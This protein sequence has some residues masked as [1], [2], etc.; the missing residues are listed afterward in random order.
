M[1][2]KFEI[3][4]MTCAACSSYIDKAVRKIDG[5]NDVSVNLLQNNMT[6]DYDHSLVTESDIA[7]AV[8]KGGYQTFKAGSSK[9]D[10]ANS[11]KQVDTLKKNFLNLILS[12]ALMI[13][14]WYLA[15]ARMLDFP[16][17]EFVKANT[18]IIV[19]GILQMVI[20]SLIL[21]INKKFF[22]SGFKALVNLAPNM[23]S[24]IAIGSGASFIYSFYSLL[25]MA[26]LVGNGNITLALEYSMNLYF[27]SAAMI[28]VFI[29]IG[30]LMESR[31]KNETK[32]SLNKLKKLEVA[33]ATVIR[34]NKKINIKSEDI[35]IGDIVELKAGSKIATDGVIITGSVSIDE[36][37][38]TGE[39]I[40]KDKDV[41]GKV[42][43]GS[44][45]TSGY[46]TYKVESL[47]IDS[48][49][50][51]I[52]ALVEDAA[53]SKAP[54]QR[55][56]DKISAVFVPF[57]ISV[58]I[59]VFII[60]FSIS[61]DFSLS[62]TFAIAVLVVSCPCA[63][64]LATPT[65]IMVA[66][67]K[68]A[69][70][71]ILF[72]EAKG[73]EHLGQV[74]TIVFDKTGTLTEG[75]AKV[76]KIIMLDDK[77]KTL[78]VIKSIEAKS[79]HPLSKAIV[80]YMDDKAIEEVEV[81]D[82]TAII[83]QGVMANYNGQAIRIGNL[84]MMELNG[85]DLEDHLQTFEEL[86]NQGATVLFVAFDKEIKAIISI[87]DQVKQD[88]LKT[89]RALKELNL[90]LVMLTGDNKLTANAIKKTLGI[91]QVIAEVLP[92]EKADVIKNLQNENHKVLMVGDG[93][94]D[95][96]ALTSSDISMAIANGTEIAVDSADIVLMNNNLMAIYDAF[97]L[98]K[99]TLTN[100]K[101]NLFL[102]LIYNVIGIPLAAGAFYKLFNLRLTPM[103]GAGTMAIS[104]T[105]VVMN[106]LRLKRFKSKQ[107]IKNENEEKLI[108]VEN[109]KENIKM[110]KVIKIEGMMCSHCENHVNEALNGLDGVTAKVVLSENLAN[111]SVSN[112]VK[113]E[114]LEQAVVN[115]GYKVVSIESR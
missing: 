9:K 102:A 2:E 48:T 61:K 107:T 26:Y 69:E 70:M 5:V 93:I 34:D 64:G 114:D 99:A 74:D 72:K 94:N 79:E 35:L 85:L 71:K 110:E 41:E 68:A 15:M 8:S 95:A 18:S 44:L 49:L 50:A 104:S 56:A 29:S 20:S 12:V 62:L 38:L 31:S 42:Y 66:T 36:A 101:Q 11:K 88:A 14:L 45:V 51:K 40:P 75:K 28:L 4:G 3:S 27:E 1:K 59:L 77:Q 25:T 63:L 82:F 30:K 43:S 53:S 21:Y 33:N 73:L 17:P 65:A 112:Q 32:D 55:L 87:K 54:I 113:D 22:I 78:E 10:V 90:N 97:M 6:I 46:A 89:I 100:I 23:D 109:K 39:S 96:L 106:A 115:A 13:I 7:N 81:S 37:A 52:I 16:L 92:D 76:S 83:G 105:I 108:K 60:W 57:V 47:A 80:D 84:K 24:L 98:S 19:N 103:F 67:G 91:D 58:A 111:V 86:S